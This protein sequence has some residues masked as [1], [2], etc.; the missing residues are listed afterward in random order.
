MV[1]NQFGSKDINT[2]EHGRSQIHQLSDIE[3]TVLIADVF[4]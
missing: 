1:W 4:Y 3:G 2:H